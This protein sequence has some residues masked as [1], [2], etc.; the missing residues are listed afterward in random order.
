M[1]Y[2][3]IPACGSIIYGEYFDELGDLGFIPDENM[4][5]V[6]KSDIIGQLNYLMEDKD[7]LKRLIQ[8]GK[9]LIHSRHTTKIRAEELVDIIKGELNNEH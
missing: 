8:N 7:N 1:K 4:I 9:D 3:E 2:F 6:D 5:V